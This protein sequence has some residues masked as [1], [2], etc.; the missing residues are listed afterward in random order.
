MLP[1]IWG[2]LPIISVAAASLPIVD[3]G[4][5]RHQAISFN[6]SPTHVTN[7][8]QTKRLALKASDDKSSI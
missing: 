5:Q 4:Y 2:C 1:I 3:L 6:V 8:K 7:K